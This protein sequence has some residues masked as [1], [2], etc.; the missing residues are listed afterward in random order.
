MVKHFP[1]SFRG[2]EL[3]GL[4]RGL[5]T[6]RL[7]L[8]GMMTHMCV[9]AT[10]RAAFDLGFACTVA[11]DACAAPAQTFGASACWAGARGLPG[12]PRGNLRH[13]PAHRRT[14]VIPV[15]R[16]WPS[17]S[18]A[19][20]A[21]RAS[22]TCV[23]SRQRPRR[24]AGGARVRLPTSGSGSGSS[25]P[26]RTLPALEEHTSRSP[27]SSV[28]SVVLVKSLW[29][30]VC[31]RGRGPEALFPGQ[32]TADAMEG[33]GRLRGGDSSWRAS[34]PPAAAASAGGRRRSPPPAP[35]VDAED[36]GVGEE[37][38]RCRPWATRAW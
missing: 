24:G 18:P 19:S 11:A 15:R 31:S 1:N 8:A 37:L 10:A 33:P 38:P 35:T 7:V 26:G 21:W 27:R 13:G 17:C 9:D 2:T 25:P 22:S 5:G 20:W 30:D 29:A 16:P 4:L 12:G 6:G 36:D 14:A 32:R 23:C 34:G 3:A 28:R